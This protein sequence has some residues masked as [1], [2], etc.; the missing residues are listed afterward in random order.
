A[1]L[2][3]SSS[4]AREASFAWFLLFLNGWGIRASRQ[5]CNLER[6]S[7]CRAFLNTVYKISYCD[8][9]PVR[10]RM[11]PF[12]GVRSAGSLNTSRTPLKASV[13]PRATLADLR[14]VNRTVMH[15]SLENLHS[16]ETQTFRRLR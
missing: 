10:G 1:K 16:P 15:F 14:P 6:N 7:P 5:E 3:L 13:A 8:T 12:S 4:L 11:N 2:L 9:V